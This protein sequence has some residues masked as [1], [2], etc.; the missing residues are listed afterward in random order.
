MKSRSMQAIIRGRMFAS[1][2]RPSSGE[3]KHA[4]FL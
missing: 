4:F 1:I 3:E 2:S